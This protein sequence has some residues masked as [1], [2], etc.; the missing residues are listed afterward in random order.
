MR[1][2]DRAAKNFL[3]PLPNHSGERLPSVSR[4]RHA[5]F[6]SG[7]RKH[8]I[9]LF[10]IK[11]KRFVVQ[12]CVEIAR[13]PA[14]R[15]QRLQRIATLNDNLPDEHRV[16]PPLAALRTARRRGR[17][18]VTVIS[19][20]IGKRACPSSMTRTKA[21]LCAGWCCRTMSCKGEAS[22]LK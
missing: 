1:D 17:G 11:L 18:A 10:Y 12:R 15:A 7:I 2:F 4:L 20:E 5:A 8:Y 13:C 14:A 6:R 9:V 16:F 22:R 21:R 19:G 3:G